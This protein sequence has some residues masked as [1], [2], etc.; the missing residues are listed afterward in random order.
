MAFPTTPVLDPLNESA[1]L[2][3]TFTTPAMGSASSIFSNA[4]TGVFAFP[5]TGS[6]TFGACYWNPT[7]FG[8]A[9]EVYGTVP[10]WGG[11]T[12]KL[13]ARITGS[14]G[15]ATYY[16]LSINQTTQVWTLSSV[17][18]G[19]ATVLTT[20]NA[21][22]FGNNNN[23]GFGMSIIGSTIQPY[24]RNGA[25][26][27][28]SAS[29]MAPFTDSSI[30]SGGNIGF[31][32]EAAN[33]NPHMLSFGGGNPILPP[34]NTAAPVATGSALVGSTLSCTT[35]SWTGSPTFTYQWKNGAG[36]ILGATAS[37]YTTLP[38]DFGTTVY[39]VVTGTNSSGSAPASSNSIGPIGA[40]VGVAPT[41]NG[42]FGQFGT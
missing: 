4:T 10:S 31:F 30:S 37:T 42:G 6:G 24:W 39:C 21:V 2:P 28:W 34:A 33:G 25:G 14:G 11:K 18:A 16:L 35:G 5:L 7:V 8:A 17:V 29:G 20:W 27:A 38:S 23:D 13:A 1:G 32:L 26:G 12:M 19:V 41:W 3:S 40:A 15:T 22:T 9:Q 36:N